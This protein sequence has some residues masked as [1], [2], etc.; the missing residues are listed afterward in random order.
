MH[1][2]QPVSRGLD[3]HGTPAES[4]QRLFEDS[5]IS[6]YKVSTF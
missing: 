5:G 6:P 2:S 4:L 1:P 3:Y